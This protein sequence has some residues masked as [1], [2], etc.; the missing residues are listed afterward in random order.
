M[1][2]IP[3]SSVMLTPDTPPPEPFT[4]SERFASLYANFPA[5]LTGGGEG[6]K[7]LLVNTGHLGDVILG[8]TAMSRVRH[9]LPKA[10]IA[11]M[12]LEPA[13]TLA[14]R[15]GVFD[16]VWRLPDLAGYGIYLARYVQWFRGFFK[17]LNWQPD[18]ALSFMADPE[19]QLIIACTKAP[20]RLG[21]VKDHNWVYQRG[22]L[23][24]PLRVPHLPV[25]RYQRTHAVADAAGLLPYAGPE[26]ALKELE[27][28]A[29]HIALAESWLEKN[30]RNVVLL[31]CGSN[32]RR[33]WP[34][35]HYVAAANHLVERKDL[36]LMVVSGPAERDLEPAI[37]RDFAQP[38]IARHIC[39]QPLMA[40]LALLQRCD[41]VATVDSG[42][43]HLAAAAGSQ[44]VYLLPE[45]KLSSF[46]PPGQHVHPI[47][48]SKVPRIEL[49]PVLRELDRV[50]DRE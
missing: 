34:L 15:L 22:W 49:D 38:K 4:Q 33:R 12:T 23:T 10:E 18:V 24:H 20:I 16:R 48:G 35:A 42:P 7:I 9:T 6:M 8:L 28:E 1:S 13:A 21:P 19:D 17:A 5:A 47:A 40:V 14:E 31:V 2:L 46:L 45:R 50:L 32:R 27:L 41:L 37:E 11:L 3:R 29:E 43:G 25:Q 36:N 44:T 26:A 39:R 30:K